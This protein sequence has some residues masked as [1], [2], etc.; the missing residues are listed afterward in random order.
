[1]D[2]QFTQDEEAFR[3]EVRDYLEGLLSGDF[4]D[5][6]GVGGPGSEHEAY[7]ERLAW[8]RRLGADGWTCLA[9]PEEFGGRGLSVLRQ[10]IWHEE[11][12][13]AGAPGRIGHIGETLVGPTIIA[14]NRITI[15]FTA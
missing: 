5:V 2:L 1:M 10:V 8:E 12:A 13:R 3:V 15:G 9:W 6:R 11:Y 7:E 14:E 4:A